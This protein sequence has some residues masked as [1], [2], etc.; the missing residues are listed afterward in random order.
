MTCIAVRMVAAFDSNSA[1]DDG[2]P[3]KIGPLS[4]LV[5]KGDIT[6]ETTDAI[7][8]STDETLDLSTG[9]H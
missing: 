9:I 6:K 2:S 7:V 3:F 8:N 5:E 1:C 4:V